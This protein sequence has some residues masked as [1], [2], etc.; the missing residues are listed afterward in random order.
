[1]KQPVITVDPKTPIQEALNTMREKGIRRLPVVD[2]KGNLKGMVAELDLLHAAPSDATSLSIWEL[3]YLLSQITVR[4]VM[5]K[6]VITVG[7]D[8]PIEDAAR[9]MADNKIGGLPVMDNGAVIGIITE[10]DLFK[11]FLELLQPPESGVRLAGLIS[12]V[13]GELAKLTKAIYDTGGNIIALGTFQGDS[14]E[15]REIMIKVEGVDGKALKKAV[16]PHLERITDMRD[17]P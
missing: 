10:T 3:N 8:A 5:T 15:T 1:M 12:D 2:G 14:P 11:V 4:S 17:S 6:K 7:Q 16:E 13:P 9:L